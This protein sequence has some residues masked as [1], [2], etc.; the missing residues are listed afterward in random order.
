[1]YANQ[2]KTIFLNWIL[3]QLDS[4]DCIGSEVRILDSSNIA[5]LVLVTESK[6]IGFE[7]KGAR[8]SF[9]RLTKQ[10]SAYSNMFHGSYLLLEQD[11]Y[12]AIAEAAKVVPVSFGILL[13][14][15][16]KITV[17]KEARFKKRISKEWAAKWLTRRDLENCLRS[18]GINPAGQDVETLRVI[19][20]RV[21]YANELNAEV[22]NRSRAKLQGR[23]CRFIAEVGK[24]VTL[25]DLDNLH[26]DQMLISAD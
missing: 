18:H 21:M 15:P 14:S 23:F 5:D 8:D 2:I 11:D 16:S 6:V 9:R 7:I 10:T 25:D 17:K 19:V 24:I 12:P 26:T 20:S 22:M 4:I 13:A 1:M 3:P